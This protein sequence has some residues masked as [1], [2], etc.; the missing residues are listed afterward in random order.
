[1]SKKREDLLAATLNAAG[2]LSPLMNVMVDQIETE[3]KRKQRQKQP[4]AARQE[5][6]DWF[7]D[8]SEDDPD[9]LAAM[10]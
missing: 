3:S 1:M 2:L 5:L 7:P 9:E 6:M 4:S 10:Y 8:A